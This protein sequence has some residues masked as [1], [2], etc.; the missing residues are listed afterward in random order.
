MEE[1]IIRFCVAADGVRIAY[2][3]VGSGPPLI[4][5]CGSPAHLEMEWRTPFLRAFLLEL[6]NGHTLVRYDMRGSGL[7]DRN[8]TDVSLPAIGRD[9]EAVIETLELERFFLLSLGEL[10]G[11]IAARYAA[12][13]PDR[14]AALVLFSSFVRGGDL[15]T[16]EKQAAVTE[17]VSSFGFPIFEFVDDPHVNAEQHRAI[18][19]IGR[20]AASYQMYAALLRT[21]YSVDLSGV[22]PGIRVPALVIHARDDRLVPFSSGR[23]AASLIPG[24]RFVALAGASPAAWAHSSALLPEIHR[25]LAEHEIPAD[26]AWPSGLTGREVDVL[27]LVAAGRSNRE[28]GE[29]LSISANTVDRHVSNILTKIGASNRAEAASFAVRHKLA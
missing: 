19:E 11:P 14:V 9:L 1:Q 20:A 6:A 22:L 13:H 18:S 15:V 3:T 12:A 7:S 21:Q 24:A 26:G 4:Y 27:R 8:V 16:A 23:E 2:A 28:I 10:A 17:W 25:F 5:V 29:E